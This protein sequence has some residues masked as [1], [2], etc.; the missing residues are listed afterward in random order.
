MSF[1]SRLFRTGTT[2]PVAAR[3]APALR[4]AAVAKPAP[5]AARRHGI[6]QL[7]DVASLLGTATSATDPALQRAAQRRLAQLIDAG[8][9]SPE[10]L[11]ARIDDQATLLAVLSMARDEGLA[12]R[13]IERLDDPALLYTLA[14][15]GA[16][17]RLRQLAAGQI[18]DVSRLKQ[19]LKAC[20][21]KDKNVHRIVKGKC[22]AFAAAEK[23]AAE[24]QA[25][26]LALAASIERHARKPYDRTFGAETEYFAGQWAAVEGLAPQDLAF[27]ARQA[28]AQCQDIIAGHERVLA[29]QAA[30]EAAIAAA[31]AQRQSLLAGL[32]EA[33]LALAAA[34]AFSATD[35]QSQRRLLA[36]THERWEQTL[37]T[38]AV[39]AQ[40]RSRFEQ[41]SAALTQLVQHSAE[42]GT[43]QEQLR[44]LETSGG[45]TG[46]EKADALRRTL[47]LVADLDAG[48]VMQ[49]VSQA[50]AMLADSGRSP[51][52]LTGTADHAAAQLEK[53]VRRALS[54]V[55][56]GRSGQA[57]GLR[58]AI[59]EKARSLDAVP[60]RIAGQI[61]QL[62]ARL[63]EFQDW[64]HYAVAPKRLELIE[65]MEALVG[66]DLEPAQLAGRIRQLQE[67]WRTLSRGAPD[68]SDVEWQ[69]FRDAGQRAYEPC[70]E[71]FKAQAEQRARN[72]E[73]RRQF[74]EDLQKF[75]VEH[76]WEHPQ[77]TL[78]RERLRM[79]RQRWREHGPTE[80]AAT[81]PVQ[82][83][84]DQALVLLQSRLDEEYARNVARRLELV[85]AAQRLVESPEVRQAIDEVKRLQA[86]W[87]ALGIVPRAKEQEL[88]LAFRER[89]DAVF[90]KSQ[91]HHAEFMARLQTNKTHA[92][93]LCTELEALARCA[94][95]AP[96]DADARVERLRTE[97]AAIE[98][99][100]RAETE[101]IRRRFDRASEDY[102]HRLSRLQINREQQ[103]WVALLD[104]AA[105]VQHWQLAMIGQLADAGALRATADAFIASVPQWPKGGLEAVRNRLAGEIPADLAANEDGLRRICI[106]AEALCGL[107]SPASDLELRR[108]FQLQTLV[109]EFG[110]ARQ[111]TQASMME[112]VNAWVGSGPVAAAAHEELAER[113]RHCVRA[114][115]LPGVSAA[116]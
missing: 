92:L 22:D 40:D 6:A 26:I 54:A 60:P 103:S 45:E 86:S 11:A 18:T 12:A 108:A 64:K 55:R 15:E 39:A 76:D 23:Q 53:L 46:P 74:V 79:A 109:E 33:L 105:H 77:W 13:A 97:F 56:E 24:Q 19:L 14:L 4:S 113:F 63:K 107:P 83:A 27:R 8:A 44:A 88:W 110:H 114:F 106:R 41:E 66:S 38:D 111:D 78:V 58:R 93:S 115:L 71:Y 43:L 95:D 37:L 49:L 52:V 50:R 9:A 34:E 35:A 2:R 69:R 17:P 101:A 81:K 5:E 16:T 89:C 94:D 25:Q 70:R 91:Q 32:H 61:E 57:A 104:A 98:A 31:R 80:H 75:V 21:G 73:Q 72:L 84:F 10:D 1:L 116:S 62:D 99:L 28:L 7:N 67:E 59:E 87:K 47:A 29:E 48:P 20:R 112:L 100:P 82:E 51:A 90:Q 65:D 42:H 68:E 36:E 30:H 3:S 102:D 85:T 96:A